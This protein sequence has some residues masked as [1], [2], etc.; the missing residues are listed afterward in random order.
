MK[1]F[2]VANYPNLLD[3][4]EFNSNQIIGIVINYNLH[5]LSV[6]IHDF[7]WNFKFPSFLFSFYKW[8]IINNDIPDQIIFFKY[9][10]KKNKD[11]LLANNFSQKILE[12]L[13]AKIFLTYLSLLRDIHLS[14]IIKEKLSLYHVQD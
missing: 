5:F 11:F 6:F 9:Y 7:E 3:E 14:V 1:L 8:I 12:G 13:K 10:F 2:Y 4:L